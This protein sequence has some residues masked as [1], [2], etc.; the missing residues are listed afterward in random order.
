MTRVAAAATM[1]AMDPKAPPVIEALRPGTFRDMKGQEWTLTSNDLAQLAAGYDPAGA[2]SPVVVGHPKHDD[3]A[4]GWIDKAALGN[5]DKLRLTLRD[6]DPAFSAAVEAKRYRKVSVALFAPD[7]PHNPKPGQWYIRH[8]GF[9]GA[10]P[11][12]V[13]GLQPV[14]FA[15]DDEGVVEFSGDEWRAFNSIGYLFRRM[16]EWF[17]EKEGVSAADQ[18][19]S[20]WMVSD[21]ERAGAAPDAT[22]TSPGFAAGDGPAPIESSSAGGGQG[23]GTN[24]HPAEMGANGSG[25]PGASAPGAS[26]QSMSP[27]AQEDPGA[28]PSGGRPVT[29]QETSVTEQEAAQLREQNATL[30]AQLAAAN[31]A[32]ADKARADRHAD[33]AAFAAGLVTQG[34]LVPASRERIVAVLDAVGELETEVEFAAGDGTAKEAPAAAL[35]TV[36]AALPVAVPLGE[37]AAAEDS[38]SAGPAFAAPAGFTVDAASLDL[39]NRAV[40]YQKAHPDTD[41]LAAVSAVSQGA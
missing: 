15:A 29:T 41:Y 7:S 14:Q 3:P 36:L 34:R 30:Q 12:A 38:A 19:L 1:A 20:D 40:A 37:R 10:M 9:L 5:D 23:A 33:N 16:R 17:I 2:P 28:T 35:R 6:L 13:T 31:Q 8:L 21:V 18:V 22:E 25:T 27:D 26:G 4:F 11:P 24:S 32:A 39:H